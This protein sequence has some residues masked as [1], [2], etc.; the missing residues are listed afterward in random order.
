[1][2]KTRLCRIQFPA[3]QNHLLAHAG[4]RCLPLQVHAGSSCLLMKG[5]VVCRF[6]IQL[7]ADVGSS[8]LPMQDL[9]ACQCKVQRPKI[10]LGHISTDMSPQNF[11]MMATGRNF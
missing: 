9:G 11:S 1:M 3:M 4:S 8:C 7:L 2:E 10:V 6:R 5:L